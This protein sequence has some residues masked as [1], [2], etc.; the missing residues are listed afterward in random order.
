MVNCAINY[1][2]AVF[3]FRRKK[4]PC[5]CSTCNMWKMPINC[6][7]ACMSGK[8][9]PETLFSISTRTTTTTTQKY[10]RKALCLHTSDANLQSIRYFFMLFVQAFSSSSS[11]SLVKLKFENRVF[12]FQMYWSACFVPNEEKPHRAQFRLSCTDIHAFHN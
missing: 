7:S 11:S 10:Y 2:F 12:Q 6:F 1:P 9:G 4:W 5:C 8:K 3:F